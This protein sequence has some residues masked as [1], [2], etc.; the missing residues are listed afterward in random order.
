M[1]FSKTQICNL[2]LGHLGSQRTIANF[3]S[4]RTPEAVACRQFYDLCRHVVL[5][6]RQWPFAR[7]FGALVPQATDPTDEWAYS[8]NLPAD[9]LV[10]R[11]ILKGRNLRDDEQYP[12]LITKGTAGKLIYCDVDEAEI[13]YT[14]DVTDPSLF[15]SDFVMALSYLLAAHISPII[16]AGDFIKGKQA[17]MALYSNALGEATANAFNEQNP[18]VEADSEFITIRG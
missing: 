7:S 3:D 8:Y 11:R 4:D 17:M 14:V 16:L 13:E 9:C 12:Y 18:D 6:A 1:S 2:A 10:P 5:K 15:D